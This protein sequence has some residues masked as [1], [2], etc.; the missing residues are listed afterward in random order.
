MT[1]RY[2]DD[3]NVSGP[4][5]LAC[6][7]FLVTRSAGSGETALRLYTYRS[8]AALVGR[9][10]DPRAELDLDYCRE[11][12]YDVSRR[13][14]GGGAIIMGS[15]QLGVALTLS[16][17]S[18]VSPTTRREMFQS[19]GSGVLEGLK[20]LGVSSA[21]LGSR[22]DIAVGGRKVAGQGVLEH[23][24]G[25]LL[26]HCSVCIGLD[27][28]EMLRILKL[29]AAK[30]GKAGADAARRRMT[31]LREQLGRDVTLGETREALRAGFCSRFNVKT[32]R[33]LLDEEEKNEVSRLASGVYA[34]EEWIF[35]RTPSP[36]MTGEGAVRGRDG[37]VQAYVTLAGRHIKDAALT[38]DFFAGP[39]SVAA[40]E[41]KLRWVRAEK[42]AVEE[43]VAAGLAGVKEEEMDAGSLAGAVMK[44][45]ANA[46]ERVK[47]GES[48]SCFIPHDRQQD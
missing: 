22:N 12:A 39:E 24:S 45:A 7:E 19:F 17:A 30:L 14:T 27:F 48:Y 18:P 44:A 32:E 46:R 33:R 8:Y 11:K 38:G 31:T 9:F 47:G 4:V 13:P 25:A 2:I 34:S 36:D 35:R 1:W 3:D 5:G 10:Q 28:E 29:P 23:G 26:Y 21:E 43:A 20:M 15:D 41:E 42:G 16:T 40:V 37:V 6:D